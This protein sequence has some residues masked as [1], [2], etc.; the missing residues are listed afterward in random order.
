M[1]HEVVTARHV[2]H[3]DDG[4]AYTVFEYQGYTEVRSMD[5]VDHIPG[6]KRLALGDGSP[7]NFKDASTFQIV[8]SS[9]IIRKAS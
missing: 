7:V 1:S 3:D 2:C 4:N 9:K 5:G 6:M 8:S